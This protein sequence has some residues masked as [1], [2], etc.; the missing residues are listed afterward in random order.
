[1]PLPEMVFG[2]SGLELRN[3]NGFVFVINAVDALR[4]VDSTH[5]LIKVAYS[6][7]WAASRYAA[8]PPMPS[9]AVTER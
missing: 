7:Q 4:L 2:Y 6:A 8:T 3:R 5:D 1:M 9:L